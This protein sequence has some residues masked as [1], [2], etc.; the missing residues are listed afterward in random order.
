MI[1][2]YSFRLSFSVFGIASSYGWRATISGVLNRA[3]V[4]N[5]SKIEQSSR[6]FCC[7]WQVTN[8][9]ICCHYTLPYIVVCKRLFAMGQV[10]HVMATTTVVGNAGNLIELKIKRLNNVELCGLNC[11]AI[12]IYIQVPH[13]KC[14]IE[15]A[16]QEQH[17]FIG[18]IF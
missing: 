7:I 13:S 6:D 12:L 16:H 4:L 10:R 2:W 18:T 1:G 15:N 8:D 5:I 3:R 17:L 9:Q 11:Y 14:Y